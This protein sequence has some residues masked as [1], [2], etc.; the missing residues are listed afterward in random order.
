MADLQGR[1]DS[2]NER[3]VKIDGEWHNYSKWAKDGAIE[4]GI[5]RGQLVAYELDK[6]GFIRSIKILGSA[7]QSQNGANGGGRER[8]NDGVQREPFDPARITMTDVLIVRQVILKA[9]TELAIEDART[10]GK[11]IMPSEMIELASEFEEWA[12]R[13]SERV[14]K[15]RDGGQAVGHAPQEQEQAQPQTAQGSTTVDG[16]GSSNGEAHFN[17]PPLG[18]LTPDQWW[19]KLGAGIKAM[20]D[21]GLTFGEQYAQS[22]L[23]AAQMRNLV[24]EAGNR[25]NAVKRFDEL[26]QGLGDEASTYIAE[27]ELK[28]S[29]KTAKEILDLIKTIRERVESKQAVVA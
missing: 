10:A 1:V 19:Q 7:S 21:H 17:I 22:Q 6:S 18:E 8:G 24:L 16:S 3:G 11:A 29:N 28:P 13:P 20:R 12:L 27:D 14:S 26:V 25:I 9:V 5:K 23:S 4:E 2:T 15:P